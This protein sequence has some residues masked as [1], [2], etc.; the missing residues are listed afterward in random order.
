M[1]ISNKRCI[2]GCLTALLVPI[3]I[4]VVAFSIFLIAETQQ[5]HFQKVGCYDFTIY[6]NVGCVVPYKYY[7][8]SKPSDNYIQA[9]RRGGILLFVA[10]DSTIYIFP[11]LTYIADANYVEFHLPK[12]KYLFFPN[13]NGAR[14]AYD[15]AIQYCEEQGYP[16]VEYVFNRW[17]H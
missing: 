13:T 5:R 17:P 3:T 12:H 2:F 11:R 10:P 8:L 9:S 1:S 16:S 6:D 7:G 4:I 14:D 15:E